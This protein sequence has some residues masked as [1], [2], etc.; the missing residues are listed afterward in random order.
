MGLQQSLIQG[1][2]HDNDPTF[3]FRV[4]VGT[5]GG[6]ALATDPNPNTTPPS[7]GRIFT[8]SM[9]GG[10]LQTHGTGR[11]TVVCGVVA[12]SSI[13]FQPWFFDTTQNLWIQFAGPVTITPVGGGTANATTIIIGNFTG[14]QFFF[15]IT[16]NTLVQALAYDLL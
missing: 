2:A 7:A 1:P 9:R 4:W 15:Q 13:T 3:A 12:A 10:M 5:I 16:A 6:S 14:A 11:L 8:A